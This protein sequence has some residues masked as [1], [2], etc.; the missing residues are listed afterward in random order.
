M[1]Q[2]VLVS[3]TL[4]FLFFHYVGYWFLTYNMADHFFKGK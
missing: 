2:I 4:D 3:K 1:K